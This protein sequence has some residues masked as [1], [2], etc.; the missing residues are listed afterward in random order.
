MITPRVQT[1]KISKKIDLFNNIYFVTFKV[2][3]PQTFNGLFYFR[4]RNKS[5]GTKSGEY[6]G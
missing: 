6:G 4:N 2:I 5:Q 1:K 3:L